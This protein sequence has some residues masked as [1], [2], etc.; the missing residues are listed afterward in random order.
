MKFIS[1]SIPYK[2]LAQNNL[3]T[4]EKTIGSIIEIVVHKVMYSL[5]IDFK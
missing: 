4:I 5:K 1:N 3:F 2:Y